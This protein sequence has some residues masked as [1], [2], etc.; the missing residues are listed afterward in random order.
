MYKMS[1]RIIQN[2]TTVP[3]RRNLYTLSHNLNKVNRTILPFFLEI[4]KYKFPLTSYSIASAGML[5]KTNKHKFWK[6]ILMNEHD[7]VS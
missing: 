2:A 6:R 1:L 4:V 3:L 5:I 7:K